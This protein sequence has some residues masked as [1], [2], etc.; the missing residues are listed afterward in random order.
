MGQKISV[1]WPIHTYSTN[2]TQLSSTV[3]T[4]ELSRVYVV[5]VKLNCQCHFAIFYTF[6]ADETVVIYTYNETQKFDF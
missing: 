5:G 1:L 6:S 2:M 3:A 4:V